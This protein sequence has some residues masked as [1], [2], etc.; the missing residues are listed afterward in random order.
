MKGREREISLSKNHRLIASCTAWE[1][2]L[3]IRHV[4]L[5]QN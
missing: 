4:P 3:K 1:L 5:I 2:S